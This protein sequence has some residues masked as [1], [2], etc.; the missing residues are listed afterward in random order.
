M[1]KPFKETLAFKIA[2]KVAP[3]IPF[4]IGSVA[5]NI[6]NDNS[7]PPGE[8]DHEELAPQLIK[9]GVY[10]VLAYLFISG[11]ISFEDAEQA[12]EFIN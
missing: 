10:I 6:L 9:I 3:I 5:E 4:G 1:K 7:T 11:K 8:V 12:K 2:Q